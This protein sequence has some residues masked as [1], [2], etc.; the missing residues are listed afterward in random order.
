M[1]AS[2]TP[3]IAAAKAVWLAHPERRDEM[4]KIIEKENSK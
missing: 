4:E 1:P 2:D 3:R